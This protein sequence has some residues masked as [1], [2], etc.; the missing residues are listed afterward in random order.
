ME[1]MIKL[2]TNSVGNVQLSRFQLFPI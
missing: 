2:Y 1:S